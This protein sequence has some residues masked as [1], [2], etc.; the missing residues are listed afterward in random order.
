MPRSTADLRDTTR[1][2][3]C[4]TQLTS[5]TCQRCGLD[6]TQ[7][8]AVELASVSAQIATSLDERA[9]LIA[10][11]RSAAMT[12]TPAPAP[13]VRAEAPAAAA[14]VNAPA[15]A[16][17]VGAAPLVTAPSAAASVSAQLPPP[18]QSTPLLA[19]PARTGR[20]S[21]VQI[22][23]LVTGISLL[24]VFAVFFMVFA[25]INYGLIWRSII[26]G[27]LTLAAFA[28]A[29]LLRRRGLGASAEAV[30]VFALIL[31]Y[32][33]AFALRA[34]GLFGLDSVDG[35][36]YWGTVLLGSAPV[37]VAC[38]RL[39]GVRAASLVGYAVAVPGV[40]TLVSAFTDGA[41]FAVAAYIVALAMALAGTVQH[42][43]RLRGDRESVRAALPERVL[44][45]LVSAPALGAAALAAFGIEARYGI[46][47]ALLGCAAV[48]AVLVTLHLRV[49][50]VAYHRVMAMITAAAAGTLVGLAAITFGT[51]T[52][53]DATLLRV[54][55][56]A[57]PALLVVLALAA[58]RRVRTG[59]ARRAVATSTGAA[60]VVALFPV[61]VALGVAA[62]DA[63]PYLASPFTTMAPTASFTPTL[64]LEQLDSII[65][66]ALGVLAAGLVLR[67]LGTHR[68]PWVLPMLTTAGAIVLLV[69]PAL[70]SA[71]GIAIVGWA[72][73]GSAGL[74]ALIL[75]PGT[76]RIAAT[77]AAIGGLGMMWIAGWATEPSWP[78][79]S[80]VAVIAAIIA[81]QATRA[82]WAR[83]VLIGVAVTLTLIAAG[84]AGEQIVG[85]T[86]AIAPSVLVAA[87]VIAA[88]S[89]VRPLPPAHAERLVALGIALVAGIPSA[90]IDAASWAPAFPLPVASIAGGAVLTMAAVVWSR[91]AARSA[92][93]TADAA[94]A[95]T[96]LVTAALIAPTLAY[97][98]SAAATVWAPESA[99]RWIA[100]AVAAALVAGLALFGEIR[101]RTAPHRRAV[102]A[103]V[104]LAL[105]PPLGAA[106]TGIIDDGWLAL[107]LAAITVGIVATSPDGL[108]GSA[109]KRRHLGW[110]ALAF[111][112]AALWW[113]LAREAVTTPE[114]YVLPPAAAL[115][116]IA[117][118]IVRRA[119]RL[120]ERP[121]AAAWLTFFALLLAIVP[122]ALAATGDGSADVTR[123]IATLAASIALLLGASVV[124][125]TTMASSVRPLGIVE[126]AIAAGAAG[127]VGTVLLTL[128]RVENALT[129]VGATLEAWLA[130]GA[131][132]LLAS[133][134]ILRQQRGVDAAWLARVALAIA[135]DRRDR[136]GRRPAGRRS[137]HHPPH[138]DRRRALSRARHR[139]DPA[140]DRTRHAHRMDRHRAR[141]DRRRRGHDRRHGRAHR[142]GDRAHRDRA[143]RERRRHPRAPTGC[144]QLAASR[145]RDRAP[146]AAEPPR[147]VPR[148]PRV[149][150]RAARGRRPARHHRRDVPEVAGALPHR[151]RGRHHP[152]A[153]NVRS[154]APRGLRACR[155]VHLGRHRRRHRHGHR[156]PLR[157][158]PARRKAHRA[159]HRVTALTKNCADE[160]LR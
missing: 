35:R 27:T 9:A 111:A 82:L 148:R 43:A 114:P 105:V 126:L 115:L 53:D 120:G 123:A 52:L 83:V 57:A 125:R 158:P 20:R 54:T 92:D 56:V 71:D 159:Q 131:I 156:H 124:A 28:A 95:I 135:V 142:A 42:T 134:I 58:L 89:A 74:A 77:V 62:S 160:G 60:A 4:F 19:E 121:N 110:L 99:A 118:L 40:G 46:G 146:P 67:I 26:I 3:A 129:S 102:D 91:A 66:L 87:S 81:R 50:A 130:P 137:Q 128:L 127:A 6:L 48:A 101:A 94:G 33:D 103:G 117:T 145:T 90:A 133:A 141:G 45:T 73:I 59:R 140:A 22:A 151:D 97:T 150:A 109:S 51:G 93:A 30:A 10:R 18:P 136:R 61:L 55:I 12:A 100:P 49:T 32:L 88:V 84:V 31:V 112:T 36:A 44:V 16:A 96:R 15:V 85:D 143:A 41:S 34:N 139:G 7:A 21:G 47:A 78:A 64:R 86:G 154:P 39:A 80:A 149:A 113:A 122:L 13:E 104:A 63:A 72:V 2:P 37:F 76:I 138:R 119:R 106:V 1:C 152:C 25:F 38:Y 144:R 24:S 157:T 153:P 8:G 132:A 70:F 108:V 107:A 17:P 155:L 23:L 65:V 5:T 116:L 14:A 68:R 98:L 79:T 69:I 147:D 75:R 29:T 11:M